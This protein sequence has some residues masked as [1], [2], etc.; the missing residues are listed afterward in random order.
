MM[1]VVEGVVAKLSLLICTYNRAEFL[2]DTL[3]SILA[4]QFSS[5]EFVEIVVVNNNSTDDTQSVTESY[6]DN[7]LCAV[8]Y[9]FEPVQGLSRARNTAIESSSGEYVAYLDD[10]IYMDNKWL[11][12]VF[13]VID[14]YPSAAAFGGKSVPIFEEAEP[15][16]KCDEAFSVYGTT[17]SG[18][19]IKRMIYPEHPFGLNM[20][21][22][23]SVFDEI[24]LFSTRLGRKKNNLL[25]GEESDMFYRMSLKGLEVVYTPHAL[26]RHRIPRIRTTRQWVM[27]RYFWQGISK[28]A[29]R[30]MVE[31][32]SRRELFILGVSSISSVFINLTGG[33]THPRKAYWHYSSRKDCDRFMV[34]MFIGRAKQ[35]FKEAISWWG[36]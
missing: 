32:R 22:K 30:Q 31:P 3:K 11:S 10:D 35:C 4:S 1:N 23:R 36:A 24:G 6:F 14:K 2:R 5:W 25:S 33:H 20:I 13:D 19:S 34:S 17:N 7:E 27:N 28:I 9:V 29:F 16:W 15:D 8:K 21:F 12:A 26:V 18:D